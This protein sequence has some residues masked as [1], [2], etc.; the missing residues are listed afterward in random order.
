MRQQTQREPGVNGRAGS[1]RRVSRNS[2]FAKCDNT[3]T[4]EVG[5]VDRKSTRLNSSHS[6]ISYAVFCLKKK[7][8][9]TA[10]VDDDGNRRI[11]KQVMNIYENE[12]VLHQEKKIQDMIVLKL[13]VQVSNIAR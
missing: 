13:M 9:R 6:Q 11:D 7:K 12:I 3:R 8:D 2:P 1:H 4:G 5:F 10:R